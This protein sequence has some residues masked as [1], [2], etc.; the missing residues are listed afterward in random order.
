MFSV[1]GDETLTYKVIIVAIV[2]RRLPIDHKYK[3][4]T[5]MSINYV[6]VDTLLKPVHEITEL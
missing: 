1:I 6:V 5:S 2:F 3:I 4:T